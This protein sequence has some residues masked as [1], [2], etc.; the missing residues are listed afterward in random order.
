MLQA[1]KILIHDP[2]KR[3][4]REAEVQ[5]GRVKIYEFEQELEGLRDDKAGAESDM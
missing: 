2:K 3:R 5:N 4:E 1:E